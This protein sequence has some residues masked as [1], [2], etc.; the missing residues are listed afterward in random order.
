MISASW[1]WMYSAGVCSVSGMFWA[2]GVRFGG[3]LRLR[4]DVDIGPALEYIVRITRRHITL[5]MSLY[6]VY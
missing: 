1:A 5:R 4:V 6:Q 3:C 2:C